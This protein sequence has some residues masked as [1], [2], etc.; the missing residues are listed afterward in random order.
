MQPAPH[1]QQQQQ[2][3][4]QAGGQVSSTDVQAILQ[5]LQRTQNGGQLPTVPLSQATS[6]PCSESA[7]RPLGINMITTTVAMLHGVNGGHAAA[8]HDGRHSLAS[9]ALGGSL[10]RLCPYLVLWHRVHVATSVSGPKC[11]LQVG[12]L[13]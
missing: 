3:D 5:Q 10:P 1:P 6:E 11:M 2:P 7:C 4:T 9:A 8:P 12:R 13:C